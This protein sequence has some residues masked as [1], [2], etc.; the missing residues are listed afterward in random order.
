VL[1][2]PPSVRVFVAAQPIDGR[3]GADSL[4]AMIRSVFLHDP[5]TGHL[6]V[7][8]SKRTDRVRLVYWD[9]DGFAMWAK[10]SKKESTMPGFPKMAS[11]R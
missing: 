1:S 6:Y 9:R 4:V 10:G 7:F 3:K 8:F 11:C 2:L 5:L